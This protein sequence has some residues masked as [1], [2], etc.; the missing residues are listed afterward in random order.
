[1]KS[2][3]ALIA[4]TAL[5]CQAHLVTRNTSDFTQVPALTVVDTSTL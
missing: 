3:D 2:P 1:M 5:V 4:A